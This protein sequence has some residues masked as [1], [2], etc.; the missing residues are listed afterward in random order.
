MPDTAI[1]LDFA[2]G[3]YRFWLPMPQIVQLERGP[4]NKPHAEAYPKS[5]FLMFDQ[6][7]AG[8]GFVGD[9]PVYV[10]GGSA[11]ATDIAETIR[12][13]LIGGNSGTVSGEHF[14]VTPTMAAQLVRDNTYPARP[15]IEGMR[16]AWEILHAA[17]AGVDVK[18]KVE[19]P[20]PASLKRSAKGRSSPTAV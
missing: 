7:G 19:S 11:L 20:R 1:E 10:G 15:L 18:K 12:L 2:D 13:A 4:V 9:A 6:M 8:L 3:R 16:L 5:V 17:I 14:E